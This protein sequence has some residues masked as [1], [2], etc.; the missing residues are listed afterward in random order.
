MKHFKLTKEFKIHLG[1]KLY[2][3]EAI[4]KSKWAEKGDNG[5]WIEKETCI[6]GNAWISGNG[7]LSLKTFGPVAPSIM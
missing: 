4:K 1:I 2:Q 5:G 7:K 3:I 6:S